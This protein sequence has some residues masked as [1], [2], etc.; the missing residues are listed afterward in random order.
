ML[1]HKLSNQESL[2]KFLKHLP[3]MTSTQPTN[4]KA[5]FD[6]CARKLR[7]NSY[8]AFHIKIDFTK[9]CQFVYKLRII[10]KRMYRWMFL[11]HRW[12]LRKDYPYSELFWSAFFPH[13]PAFRLNTKIYGVR[14]WFYVFVNPQIY[15]HYI[16]L[17]VI[18]CYH[19][20]IINTCYYCSFF[21]AILPRQY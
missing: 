19:E 20:N 1:S 21:R 8:K 6:T 10:N 4:Q 9:S 14:L 5:N 7:K 13:F 16:I 15:N 12:T 17:E 18:I 2:R 3:F 11:H